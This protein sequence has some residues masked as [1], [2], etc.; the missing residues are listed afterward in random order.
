MMGC[1][2]KMGLDKG[3][4]KVNSKSRRNIAPIDAFMIIS[5][6]FLCILLFLEFL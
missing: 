4:N 3:P 6:F 1:V 2:E 5:R